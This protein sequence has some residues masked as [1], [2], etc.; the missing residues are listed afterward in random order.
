MWYFYELNFP[1][2]TTSSLLSNSYPKFVS[3][4]CNSNVLP[5]CITFNAS[6]SI[7]IPL[8]K[9]IKSS[10]VVA[11]NSFGAEALTA[12]KLAVVDDIEVATFANFFTKYGGS[13]DEA[14]LSYL[15]SLISNAT[16]EQ[17]Q[18]ESNDFSYQ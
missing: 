16:Q 10:S 11:D 2:A 14:T 15:L 3:S 5:F 1:Q 17:Q 8:L 7:I 13:L 4:I 12:V 9:N 6:N 18:E